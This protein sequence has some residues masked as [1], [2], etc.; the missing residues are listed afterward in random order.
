MEALVSTRRD[1]G[2]AHLA[3]M[4]PAV[5]EHSADD[6]RTFVLRPFQGSATLA[7]L[8]RERTGVL[9][10]TDDVLLLA[11]AAIGQVAP[12]PPLVTVGEML[13][14]AAHCEVLRRDVGDAR[15]SGA[16]PVELIESVR[17]Q[18]IV[19][20][21]VRWYAFHV[22]EADLSDE[23][24]V[25]TSEVVARGRVR[26]FFGFNRAKHAVVEAAILA[27]RVH[28]LPEADI[29]RQLAPLRSA[30]DKTGGKRERAAFEMLVYHLEADWACRR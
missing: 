15:R 17:E 25:L 9:H 18:F 3:P 8:L 2:A 27:T 22:V 1:D 21:A 12:L 23:R 24:A 28:L 4:G 6:L 7:N 5:D 13:D 16:P 30:I 14:R 19:A 26:E 11:Q 10:V 29:R 20:D